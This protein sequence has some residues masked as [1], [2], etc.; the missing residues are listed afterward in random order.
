MTD[1]F[2]P[3]GNG[4]AQVQSDDDQHH[5][6]VSLWVG[7]GL[8]RMVGRLDS[9]PGVPA[10]YFQTQINS[11]TGSLFPIALGNQFEYRF[12][13]LTSAKPSYSADLIVDAN[14]RATG[15]RPASAFYKNLTGDAFVFKCD[16]QYSQ[17]D[18]PTSKTT[19]ARIFFADLGY[20][21]TVDTIDPA[22]VTAQSGYRITLT[23]VVA[24]H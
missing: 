13:Q 16:Y 7:N 8:F 10:I 4:L 23:N 12:S 11:L 24:G 19:G 14:C 3:I 9:T 22:D 5:R 15:K 20:F 17:K 6:T 2:Q 18:Q 21:L 1:K